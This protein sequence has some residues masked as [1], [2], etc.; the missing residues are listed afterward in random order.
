[1]HAS[2][3]RTDAISIFCISVFIEF[4]RVSRF[5]GSTKTDSIKVDERYLIPSDLLDVWQIEKNEFTI[6]AERHIGK[7]Y[8]VKCSSAS[9]RS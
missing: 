6:N 1:M 2:D 4:Y 9:K 8:F 5:K 7:R 3:H